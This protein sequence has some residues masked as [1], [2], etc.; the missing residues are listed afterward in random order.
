MR[1]DGHNHALGRLSPAH[2]LGGMASAQGGR[3]GEV[4][5]RQRLEHAGFA[6][7]LVSNDDH[8]S[9]RQ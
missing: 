7:T 8:L 6:G 3:T 1:D 4:K 5:A 2:N 9:I